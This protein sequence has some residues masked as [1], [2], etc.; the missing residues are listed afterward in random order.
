MFP[1]ALQLRDLP[2]LEKFVYHYNHRR[3]EPENTPAII[4]PLDFLQRGDQVAGLK[5]FEL[6]FNQL[7]YVSLEEALSRAKDPLWNTIDILL[8]GPR[9]GM[10]RN[11]T[12]CFDIPVALGFDPVLHSGVPDLRAEVHRISNDIDKQLGAAFYASF[13]R[14]HKSLINLQVTAQARIAHAFETITEREIAESLSLNFEGEP[15]VVLLW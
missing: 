14:L 3:S 9:F 10:L 11:V 6:G 12:L 1:S 7:Y 8:T 13:P 2:E 5:K 4:P 15:S